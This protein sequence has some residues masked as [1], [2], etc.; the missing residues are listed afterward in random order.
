MPDRFEQL[1]LTAPVLR[2]RWARLCSSRRLDDLRAD[3]SH[4]VERVHGALE[5]ERDVDPAMRP[6]SP[7]SATR[8]H[9]LALEEH[10]PGD[11]RV[12]GQQPEDRERRRRLSAPG[13][14]DQ[15]EPLTGSR[16]RG[17]TF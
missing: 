17:L 3:G 6:A 13:L 4:R 1:R 15:A 8:Q 9:V 12:R 10:S 7:A 11:A 16:A 14:A 5:H 2:G